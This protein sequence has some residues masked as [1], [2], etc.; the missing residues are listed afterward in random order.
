MK[1][2]EYSEQTLEVDGWPL[3]LIS[4]KLVGVFHC[5][6]DNVSPG[7]RLARTTGATREEAEEKAV[8]RARELLSRTRLNPIP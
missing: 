7:A 5:T 3:R 1:P 8:A 2:E 6:A 4:Y